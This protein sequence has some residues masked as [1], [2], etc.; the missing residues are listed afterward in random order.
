MLKMMSKKALVLTL[1]SVLAVGA[2]AA[3]GKKESTD[4]TNTGSTP[5]STAPS[6]TTAPAKA[7]ITGTIG[8][9]G[10]TALQPLVAFAAQEF[11]KANPKAT[12]NVTG[13]GS[14]TGVKNVADGISE[15][16]N[17]DV[18]AAAEYKDKLKDHIVVI[19]PF[20]LIVNKDVKVDNLTGQQMVD[21]YTGKITNWKDV[22]GQD[23]K[24]Q[25]VH[26][27]ESSGTRKLVGTIVMKGADF[28]KE[29]LTQD[30]SDTVAKTVG[31]TA[32]AVGYVDV[33]YI[34]KYKDT[35]KGLKMDGVEFSADNIKSGKYPL[36]AQEH[37][38]T[39]G[40]PSGATKAFL[41][42][43]M[44]K[45]FLSKKEVTDMGFLPA[46]LLKK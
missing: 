31:Q 17:S 41:E 32:G 42:Y 35:I 2:L 3:C 16:G 37:M 11:M 45:D 34:N 43:I 36:Y 38:Y 9:S 10:S 23:L 5:A 28:S 33:P 22:G 15:I 30:S 4:A 12:V 27:Q 19:A 24:I 21:I 7:E 39:K 18:E 20:A 44:S 46:D 14:G 29:G 40:E 8:A 13:G 26:R 25:L 1:T 6:A